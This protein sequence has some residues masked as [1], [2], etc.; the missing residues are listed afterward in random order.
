[1][2]C[3][4]CLSPVADGVLPRPSLEQCV[5]EICGQQLVRLAMTR[6]DFVEHLRNGGMDVLQAR[7]EEDKIDEEAVDLLERLMVMRDEELPSLQLDLE[8][9]ELGNFSDE[10]EGF[11]AL[12]ERANRDV[13]RRTGQL[14]IAALVEL[15]RRRPDFEARVHA[16]LDKAM[17]KGLGDSGVCAW[18]TQ[19]T[20][21]KCD[22][23]TRWLCRAHAPA[24]VHKVPCQSLRPVR[25]EADG[26]ALLSEAEADVERGVGPHVTTLL[27]VGRRFPALEGRVRRV[28]DAAVAKG[29]CSPESCS[30]CSTLGCTRCIDCKA[31]LCWGL[32]CWKEHLP[33]CR[34]KTWSSAKLARRLT[35]RAPVRDLG[36][37]TAL[38]ERVLAKELPGA[39]MALCEPDAAAQLPAEYD[40]VFAAMLRGATL[41]TSVAAV[42]KSRLCVRGD[43]WLGRGNV[44]D[45]LLESM[46]GGSQ[47]VLNAGVDCLGMHFTKGTFAMA[48]KPLLAFA[49][50][51]PLAAEQVRRLMH[52]AREAGRLEM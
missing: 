52:V 46:N 15:A 36:L 9:F 20:Y 19:R 27:A 49:K 4:D 1:M 26:A 16:V 34:I 51:N 14:P 5:R 21:I 17:K 35:A 30:C 38:A 41:D 3:A 50:A 11:S 24:K 33:L 8:V 18:C 10:D 13:K 47:A 44:V 37:V 31:P 43:D 48:C 23:C 45:A 25:R 2:P 22:S 28:V 12:L 39:L 7:L 42:L 6:P 32:E 40:D 29:L